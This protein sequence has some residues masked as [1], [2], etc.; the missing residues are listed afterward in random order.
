MSLFSWAPLGA[1]VLGGCNSFQYYLLF[2]I[3]QR[4][5]RVCPNIL[6]ISQTVIKNVR[7]YC[8]APF[9]LHITAGK[10]LTT[11]TIPSLIYSRDNRPQMQAIF[12]CLYI[13]IKF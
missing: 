3:L 10:K 1:S 12:Q 8:K 9:P 13:Y 11:F 7:Q 6:N 4:C 5:F 2:F